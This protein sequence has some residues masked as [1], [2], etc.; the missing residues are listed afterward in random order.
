VPDEAMKRCAAWCELE[1]TREPT[2]CA[3]T[4][5]SSCCAPR[6]HCAGARWAS[7]VGEVPGLAQH[8]D[9]R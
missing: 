3:P 7:L 9:L 8:R 1:T 6:G 2:A 4:S 5:A